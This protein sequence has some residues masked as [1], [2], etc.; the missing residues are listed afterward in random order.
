MKITVQ[1]FG[2]MEVKKRPSTIFDHL[3]GGG[4]G[5]DEDENCDYYLVSRDANGRE[6]AIS[7]DDYKQFLGS[8]HH[9]KAGETETFD[10]HKVRGMTEDE[11]RMWDIGLLDD[12]MVDIWGNI[13]ID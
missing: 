9:L 5:Y 12:T 3:Q 11:E 13:K 10:G 1:C 4:Y 7:I 2:V 8:G 6:C